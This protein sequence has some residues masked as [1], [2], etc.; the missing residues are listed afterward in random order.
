MDDFTHT[1]LTACDEI[2]HHLQTI[3]RIARHSFVAGLLERDNA[4][5]D[6][7]RAYNRMRLKIDRVRSSGGS[8]LHVVFLGNFNAGKSSLINALGSVHTKPDGSPCEIGRATDILPT[9]DCIS[10]LQYGETRQSYRQQVE[11]G[12]VAVEV[13]DYPFLRN[14]VLVDTPGVGNVPRED[15]L[16]N[17]YL[18][19]VDLLVLVSPATMPINEADQRLLQ[20]KFDRFP[21]AVGLIVVTRIALEC[22]A[23]GVRIDAVDEAKAKQIEERLRSY[24]RVRF[25]DHIGRLPMNP[26]HTQ[27]LW[28]V[29][30]KCK[31][32]IRELA[33]Y[34]FNRFG[35]EEQSVALRRSLLRDRLSL[36]A[37]ETVETLIAP[38]TVRLERTAAR[39]DA[40]LGE[41][42][43]SATPLLSNARTQADV[44]IHLLKGKFDGPPSRSAFM[45]LDFPSPKEVR[46]VLLVP[47]SVREA[48]RASVVERQRK[49]R[50]TVETMEE[51]CFLLHEEKL[52]LLLK[53]SETLLI[54]WSEVQSSDHTHAL[55]QEY[56]ARLRSMC[57][58]HYQGA[59]PSS[60]P[61][62]LASFQGV[63]EAKR[64]RARQ[65]EFALV[66]DA[67]QTEVRRGGD[68][69]LGEVRTALLGEGAP[70]GPLGE[71]GAARVAEWRQ[72]LREQTT[73]WQTKAT[74][75]M[76]GSA[77]PKRLERLTD[78]AQR[79]LLEVLKGFAPDFT[80]NLRTL[81]EIRPLDAE[82]LGLEQKPADGE[83][84]GSTELLQQVETALQPVVQQFL[85]DCATEARP[86]VQEYLNG[87]REASNQTDAAT[88]QTMTRIIDHAT[89]V[90]RD[91]PGRAVWNDLLA[92]TDWRRLTDVSLR[93]TAD[94][95]RVRLL[96]SI[97]APLLEIERGAELHR[98]RMRDHLIWVVVLLGVLPIVLFLSVVGWESAQHLEVAWWETFQSRIVWLVPIVVVAGISG[99]VVRFRAS[100][101]I[102]RETQRML[103][104]QV[105][106][107]LLELERNV[108]EAHDHLRRAA[109][110]R[111]GLVRSALKELFTAVQKRFVD[112]LGEFESHVHTDLQAWNQA[113]LGH[114]DRLLGQ[115]TD[116]KERL[117]RD[118]VARSEA[119]QRQVHSRILTEL[120]EF[121]DRRLTARKS[122]LVALGESL[123]GQKAQL[124]ESTRFMTEPP[125]ESALAQ[126]TIKPSMP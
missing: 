77:P 90:V 83:G 27:S 95:H 87:V 31:Y 80:Q 85:T 21:S 50:A 39:L 14:V 124:D 96:Q 28:L 82:R 71:M 16:I 114:C 30:S 104:E 42:D 44:L 8:A 108:N 78:E 55:Q 59:L 97:E 66:A 7:R 102:Q 94:D 92:G 54:D 75:T 34:L 109:G 22:P 70:G 79:E 91:E 112:R 47:E 19:E 52:R 125:A 99:C 121:L 29:D 25:P 58:R 23:D 57:E 117:E 41:L 4:T 48:V 46:D 11:G 26:P 63:D 84:V 17:D 20:T 12:E 81:L 100:R 122:Q 9:D 107:H 111:I 64:E 115:I 69:F 61:K 51:R 86:L 67:L 118:G 101:E 68:R 60:L 113:T 89:A 37:R 65:L 76:D 40:L 123:K 62:L 88:V 35:R 116:V 43:R 15:E 110:E 74:R 120:E 106:R 6:V 56:A 119:F 105:Q 36:Y 45:P 3:E 73:A 13:F 24:L 1:V 93:K 32:N 5:A 126:A 53:D 18:D 2:N 72:T 10:L 103:N 33:D 49:A 38:L 98:R